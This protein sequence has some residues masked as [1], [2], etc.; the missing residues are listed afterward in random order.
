MKE[1]GIDDKVENFVDEKCDLE[2]ENSITISV[3][4]VSSMQLGSKLQWCSQWTNNFVDVKF[5]DE[6]GESDDE[7]FSL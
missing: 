1:V 6:F 5:S 3:G 2:H 7:E 4:G